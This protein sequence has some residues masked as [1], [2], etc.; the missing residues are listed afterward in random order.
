MGSETVVLAGH[1]RRQQ[2]IVWKQAC[3]AESNR[4]S[5]VDKALCWLE[6]SCAVSTGTLLKFGRTL[7]DVYEV[8][9]GS[10]LF[11]YGGHGWT[12]CSQCIT[13]E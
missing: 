13:T 9:S 6:G 2:F 10:V 11:M 4:P 12:D 7:T 8:G 3:I 5:A 1:P